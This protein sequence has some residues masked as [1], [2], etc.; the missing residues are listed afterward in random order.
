VTGAIRAAEEAAKKR[1][2]EQD[3][4][5]KEK[6]DVE[7]ARAIL[8][9]DPALLEGLRAM[10]EADLRGQINPFATEE[11]FWTQKDERIQLTVL[12]FLCVSAPD[13]LAADRANSK[14]KVAKAIANLVAKFP[15]VA[16][17][18]P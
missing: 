5:T 18:K 15:H 6:A 1:T 3:R 7:T 13:L 16:Q 8:Q 10:K 2:A 4:Q 14:S 11:R 9:P 12:H 17:P